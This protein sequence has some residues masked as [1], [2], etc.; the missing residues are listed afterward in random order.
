MFD[1]IKEYYEMGLYTKDD[2]AT[3][4]VSGM[5]TSDQ[6]DQLIGGQDESI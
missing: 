6:Y 1:Y 3:F 2:L 4:K 5:I